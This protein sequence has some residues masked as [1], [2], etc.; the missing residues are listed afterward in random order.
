MWRFAER[1]E[2]WIFDKMRVLGMEANVG[3]FWNEFRNMYDEVFPWVE[4]KRER[5]DVEKQW[6]DNVELEGL[7]EEKGWL[8]SGKFN[9][10]LDEEG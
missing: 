10:V 7:E 5:K 2:V 6:L 3:R 4:E 1:L 9:G 8:Y